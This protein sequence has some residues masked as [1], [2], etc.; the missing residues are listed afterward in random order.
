MK[1]NGAWILLSFSVFGLTG[2]SV[3]AQ[4]TN[5]EKENLVVEPGN[6]FRAALQK[7]VRLKK[8]GQPITAKLLEPVYAGETLAIPA[9]STV[10]GHVSSIS[11][12]PM[13]KRVGRLL[14]IGLYSAEDRAR[15]IRSTRAFRRK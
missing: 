2:I 8:V 5:P 11:K 12:I 9:G 3:R 13:H 14:C 7:G 6:D 10:K 4:E 15:D 1:R